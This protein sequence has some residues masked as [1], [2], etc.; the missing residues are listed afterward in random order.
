M[1][2]EKDKGR[3]GGLKGGVEAGGVERGGLKRRFEREERGGCDQKE[4][5]KKGECGRRRHMGELDVGR[6]VLYVDGR[7]EDEVAECGRG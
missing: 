6:I 3:W 2:R 5:D 1:L 4:G 7:S